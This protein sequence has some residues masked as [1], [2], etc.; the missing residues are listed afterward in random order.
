MRAGISDGYLSDVEHG[1][2]A[3]TSDFLVRIAFLGV[4]VESL[5]SDSILTSTGIGT[6]AVASGACKVENAAGRRFASLNRTLTRRILAVPAAAE[7]DLARDRRRCRLAA[8][9]PSAC[10]SRYGAR[11]A[12]RWAANWQP[13][14]WRSCRQEAEHFQTRPGGYF[15][16]MVAK[17]KTGE[18]N[19]ERT[20]VGLAPG[21]GAEATRA[22]QGRGLG[23]PPA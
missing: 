19:L 23:P 10:R 15:H 20:G 1:C 14:Q 22:G 4:S 21:R 7:P 9:R 17:A 16:G 11:H 18:L 3:V 13:W 8:T 5:F 6:P 12:S 2:P